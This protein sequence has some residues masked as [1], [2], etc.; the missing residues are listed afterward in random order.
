MIKKFF[1]ARRLVMLYGNHNI[2]FRSKT[3]VRKNLY[4]Y[5]DEFSQD[6]TRAAR[7]NHALSRWF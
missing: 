5:Y 7:R 6:T 4:S 3:F 1:D 2:Y